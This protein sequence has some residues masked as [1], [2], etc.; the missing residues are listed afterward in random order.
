MAQNGI[1]HVT[2]IGGP[3]RRNLDFCT[4]VLGLRLAKKTV[5]F[6]DPSSYHL[7]YGDETGMRGMILTF[8]RWEHDAPRQPRRRPAA[9]VRFRPLR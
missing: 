6:D 1:H 9:G 4:R 7:Y 8:F 5:N 3:A 2:A